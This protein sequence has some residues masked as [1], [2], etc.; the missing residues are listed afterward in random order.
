ML[1]NYIKNL[2]DKELLASYKSDVEIDIYNNFPEKQSVSYGT[3]KVYVICEIAHRWYLEK[4]NS[5][6]SI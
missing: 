5:E 1:S 4:C 6:D 2:S 3:F